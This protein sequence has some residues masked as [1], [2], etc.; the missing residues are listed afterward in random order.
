L[1]RPSTQGGVKGREVAVAY[2]FFRRFA[3]F[4]FFAALALR[5][6]AMLPS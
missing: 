1:T 4:A 6:F 2:L 3:F 5:F